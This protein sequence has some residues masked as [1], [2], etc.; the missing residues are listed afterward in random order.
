VNATLADGSVR[1]VT[2]QVSPAV[3]LA[4]G[5]RNGGESTNGLE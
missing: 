3:W 4:A 2:D 5:S 1:F